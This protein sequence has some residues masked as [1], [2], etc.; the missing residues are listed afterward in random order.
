MTF[1]AQGAIAI[2]NANLMHELGQSTQELA[3]SIGQLQGLN[4]VGEAV[5]SSWTCARC[6]RR[7]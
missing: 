3:R 1:A 7:L 4:E 6:W 2:R 5:S